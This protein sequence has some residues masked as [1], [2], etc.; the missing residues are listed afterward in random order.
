LLFEDCH[1]QR[2]FDS[3]A[4]VFRKPAGMDWDGIICG[5]IICGGMVERTEGSGTGD[6]GT[7]PGAVG[8]GFGL[9]MPFG[10]VP[11]LYG[12]G[13]GVTAPG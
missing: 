7:C 9:P 6:N 1:D 4:D 10:I 11:G 12:G 5:G 8:S 2:D 13:C 3:A